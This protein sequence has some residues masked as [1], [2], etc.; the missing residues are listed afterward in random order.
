MD[1]RRY[2]PVIGVAVAV[3]VIVAVII[4]RSAG[5]TGSSSSLG[6]TTT[7]PG[8][9]VST[10]TVGD[11]YV[12]TFSAACN[13]ALAPARRVLEKIAAKQPLSSADKTAIANSTKAAS[14]A[15]TPKEFYT[16][17]AKELEPLLA[18]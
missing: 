17:Q 10:T 1:I 5:G 18:P 16:F 2:L 9:A 3:V 8:V 15:C 13:N 6:T 11:P 12:S 4:L 14:T 7:T